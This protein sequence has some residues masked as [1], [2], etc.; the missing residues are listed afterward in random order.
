MLAANKAYYWPQWN[1][2]SVANRLISLS[3]SSTSLSN[4]EH[5]SALNKSSVRN[6]YSFR[7]RCVIT[8][9]AM[10][11]ACTVIRAGMRTEKT[12]FGSCGRTEEKVNKEKERS[13]S[14]VHHSS[15]S[16]PEEQ[17]NLNATK[18]PVLVVEES[19]LPAA[20]KR[21]STNVKGL[22]VSIPQN[23]AFKDQVLHS[24]LP[25]SPAQLTW[26]SMS[27]GNGPAV[28][29]P[30]ES[31]TAVMSSSSSMRNEYENEFGRKMEDALERRIPSGQFQREDESPGVD[32]FGF[33]SP[34]PFPYQQAGFTGRVPIQ[35]G[36]GHHQHRS[37]SRGPHQ[38]NPSFPPQFGGMAQQQ[39]IPQGQHQSRISRSGTVGFGGERLFPTAQRSSSS[40]RSSREHQP[41]NHNGSHSQFQQE[42][43]KVAGDLYQRQKDMETCGVQM[44]LPTQAA[45][46]SRKYEEIE[47]NQMLSRL[48]KMKDMTYLRHLLDRGIISERMVPRHLLNELSNPIYG[49]Q[50]PPPPQP[51]GTNSGLPNN[52]SSNSDCPCGRPKLHSDHSSLH[53]FLPHQQTRSQFQNAPSQ[54]SL[55]QP[56]PSHHPFRSQPPPHFS[57]PQSAVPM[58]QSV[59]PKMFESLLPSDNAFSIWLD[60]KPKI[61]SFLRPSSQAP[62]HTDSSVSLLSKMDALRSEKIP[63][64]EEEIAM[65]SGPGSAAT[66]HDNGSSS[67]SSSSQVLSLMELLSSE[68]LLEEKIVKPKTTMFDFD[69]LKIA[70]TLKSSQQNAISLNSDSPMYMFVDDKTPGYDESSSSQSGQ[71]T[72]SSHMDRVEL[73][74]FF[75][76]GGSCPFGESCHM[77]HA[78]PDQKELNAL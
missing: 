14:F 24:S 4:R 55:H 17:E 59:P 69:S 38:R 68:N 34:N 12:I 21:P 32:D 60:P 36:P 66:P 52:R 58:E 61:G 9:V 65:A 43:W 78:I 37:F 71:F 45:P 67:E 47:V 39:T 77:K 23:I 8:G 51:S 44:K 40:I 74:D 13:A 7:Q 57:I 35:N 54:H 70:E 6:P 75:V 5:N 63:I 31:V 18:V 41:I 33:L 64:D 16:S 20:P 28:E 62:R 73:C 72:P 19:K 1:V 42:I 49:Q 25:L 76:T 26:I 46:P 48:S 56:A 15:L 11:P 27:A 3:V 29:K 2:P 10:G 22:T 50:P 30:N 53:S